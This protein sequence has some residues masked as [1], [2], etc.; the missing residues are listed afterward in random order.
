MSQPHLQIRVA[1][2]TDHV[3]KGWMDGDMYLAYNIILQDCDWSTGIW[4][5]SA[6]N[7]RR[8][9]AGNGLN[10]PPSE[11]SSGLPRRLHHVALCAEADGQLRPRHQ[12]LRPHLR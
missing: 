9:L 5:G 7:W 12:Q 11:C 8:W 10:P 1:L 2:L 4:H 3:A 6:D